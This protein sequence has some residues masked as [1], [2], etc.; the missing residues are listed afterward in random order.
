M[1]LLVMMYP[2]LRKVYVETTPTG[3]KTVIVDTNWIF[4][5]VELVL[6]DCWHCI[7]MVLIRADIADGMEIIALSSLL[8][9]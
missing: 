8:F 9:I 2:I 1:G 7:A 3:P 4:T 5:C 6:R